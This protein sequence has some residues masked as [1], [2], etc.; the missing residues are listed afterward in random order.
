MR[1]LTP[2]SPLSPLLPEGHETNVTW[3]KLYLLHEKIEPAGRLYL[4]QTVLLCCSEKGAP[5]RR[6]FVVATT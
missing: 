6:S 4:R 2:G 3:M 1:R 5:V